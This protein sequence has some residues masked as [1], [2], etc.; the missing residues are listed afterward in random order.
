MVVD[1]LET[2]R[3]MRAK[4]E[5][6]SYSNNEPPQI[7]VMVCCGGMLLLF[8]VAPAVAQVKGGN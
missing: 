4:L 7:M 3:I 8:N 5:Q 1:I 2:P 6:F